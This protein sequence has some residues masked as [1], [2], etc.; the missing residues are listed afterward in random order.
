MRR[1]QEEEI[2]PCCCHSLYER[3]I[4]LSLLLL[5]FAPWSC[6]GYLS[7]V[8]LDVRSV[9]HFHFLR[10]GQETHDRDANYFSSSCYMN[11]SSVCSPLSKSPL[12]SPPTSSSSSL[13]VLHS[14]SFDINTYDEEDDNL[15]WD[16]E[17]DDDDDDEFMGLLDMDDDT[18]ESYYERLFLQQ[19]QQNM[20]SE[21]NNKN[22]SQDDVEIQVQEQRR[23]MSFSSTRT[24]TR[25]PNEN[26]AT[27]VDVQTSVSM[28][29]ERSRS[30][31]MLDEVVTT[32]IPITNSADNM[33]GNVNVDINVDGV[34]DV[35]LDLDTSSSELEKEWR[36]KMHNIRSESIQNR[37]QQRQKLKR[38]QMEERA[39]FLALRA[40]RLQS[41]PPDI[42]PSLHISPTSTLFTDNES[43][44]TAGSTIPSTSSEE[45]EKENKSRIKKSKYHQHTFL[46]PTPPL[47]L[48]ASRNYKRRDDYAMMNNGSSNDDDDDNYRLIKMEQKL[49]GKRFKASQRVYIRL[50]ETLEDMRLEAK[51][52][53]SDL[54][55]D[56]VEEEVAMSM[57]VGAGINRGGGRGSSICYKQRAEEV[58]MLHLRQQVRMST[59]VTLSLNGNYIFAK[60]DDGDD[61]NSNDD[62][63]HDWNSHHRNLPH[64]D[65]D[66]VPTQDLAAILR[67]RGNVKRRGRLPKARSKVLEQM[68]ES[69][70]VPLF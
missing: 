70:T 59:V 31:Q 9:G 11:T 41:L 33:E 5:F 62:D 17:E 67:I 53:A 64:I 55:A 44:R 60:Y 8:H 26:I 69:Y 54:I 51:T 65:I 2:G 57:S 20:I 40:L 34:V 16:A 42:D 1:G 37:K 6:E 27:M 38:Q 14:S 47:S 35:E 46:M 28:T 21:K 10:Q 22:K 63:G 43:T 12:S 32:S 15:D 52:M 3:F 29:K 39:T 19:A 48:S 68:Q 4:I 56:R 61:N 45:E 30:A 7:H 24:L 49:Y 58:E 18:D 66:D 25:T 50:L 13:F 23:E 36:V